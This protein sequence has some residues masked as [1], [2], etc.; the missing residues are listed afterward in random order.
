VNELISYIPVYSVPSFVKL[1]MVEFIEILI[2]RSERGDKLCV[3]AFLSLSTK[4]VRT[5]V[6]MLPLS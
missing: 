6:A 4:F 5:K 1:N 3:H 2:S